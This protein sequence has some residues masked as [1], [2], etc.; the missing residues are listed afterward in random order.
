MSPEERY[1]A[2]AHADR[3]ELTELADAVLATPV[4]IDVLAGP[5][6]VTAP[7]RHE[8]PGTEGATAVLGHVA[9]STCAVLLDGVRGDGVRAGRDLEAAL[10]AAVCDAEAE[11]RG[12]L[13]PRVTDLVRAAQE[14]RAAAAV[15]R[16]AAVEATR[17]E[18]A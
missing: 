10:A 3:A 14:A 9:L 11:R 1:E 5:E 7:V 18:D 4:G 6:A 13:E 8:V 15:A 17:T 2:L 12:P 16:A